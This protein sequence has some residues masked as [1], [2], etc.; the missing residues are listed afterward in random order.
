MAK[1]NESNERINTQKKDIC[2]NCGSE[3]N[4]VRGAYRFKE[5]GVPV[6]L[7]GIEIIVCPKCKNED[8]I[9][10]RMNEMM[11]VLALAIIH[12]PMKLEGHDIRFLR[13]YLGMTGQE[14]ATLIGVTKSTVSRWENNADDVG[15]HNDRLI[16]LISLFLSDDLKDHLG[17]GEIRELIQ[18]F[19]GIEHG[20]HVGI[21][22]DPAK[23][24]YQYA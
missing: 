15:P 9:I 16:R 18:C 5:S 12:K 24:S 6:L 17:K 10:P 14:L 23:K 7:K 19:P 1:S 3:A 8:P 13:K 2:S 11:Q 21:H 4:V 22:I 20:K